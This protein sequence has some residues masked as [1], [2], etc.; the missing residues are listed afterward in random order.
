MVEEKRV[1][2]LQKKYKFPTE[3]EVSDEI[4]VQKNVVKNLNYI[5]FKYD[6]KVQ[7]DLA[8]ILDIGAPQLTKIGNCETSSQS[9][10]KLR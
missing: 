5:M 10:L 8:D 7:K 6:I 1:K 9:R 2:E 4:E 3:Q